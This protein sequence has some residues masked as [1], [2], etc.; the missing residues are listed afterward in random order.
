VELQ[1]AAHALDLDR[2]RLVRARQALPLLARRRTLLEE[3]KAL[4]DV[5]P[6]GEDA[7][8]ERTEAEREAREA[9]A[10]AERLRAA[11]GTLAERRAALGV[12][13]SLADDERIGEL[14]DRLGGH[15]KAASDLLNVR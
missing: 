5:P 9:V 4:G 2:S 15:R 14:Q 12:P 10:R 6:L 3:R 1:E 8:R 13:G 11:L 7:V